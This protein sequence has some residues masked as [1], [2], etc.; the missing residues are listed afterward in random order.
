MIVAVIVILA[1][2]VY[3]LAL[4]SKSQRWK[5][6]SPEE[7]NNFVHILEK[8]LRYFRNLSPIAK[9]NF[10]ERTHEL[11]QNLE[12]VGKEGLVVTEE[13]EFTICATA[14]QL[15]FGL[16]PFHFSG[17][18]KIYI[19]PEPFYVSQLQAELRGAVS[20]QGTIHLSWRNYEEGY[21]TDDDGINLGLHEMAHA[22]MVSIMDF[23]EFDGQ[24]RYRIDE[25]FSFTAG[26]LSEQPVEYLKFFRKYAF[27]NKSEFLAVAVEQFFERPIQFKSALPELY[28]RMTTLL[29]QD[30]LNYK[31]DYQ[32]KNVVAKFARPMVLN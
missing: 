26:I 22:L 2:G 14:V 32:V 25:W 17:F 11:H 9:Q 15:S 10:A 8:N 18:E 4:S 23:E 19:Y 28:S 1:V 21:F 3:L 12:F 7:K 30:P 31:Q 13:M 27:T 20:P 16:E 24:Y 6:L 29:D 5:G